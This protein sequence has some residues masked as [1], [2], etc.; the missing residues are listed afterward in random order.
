MTRLVPLSAAL[1]LV[2][3]LP[4][5]QALA[6]RLGGGR[7]IG[8]RPSVTQGMPR[9]GQPGA[10]LNRGQEQPQSG[11]QAGQP[12]AQGAQP[13]AQA[14]RPGGF[15]SRPGLGGLFGGLLMGGLLG[16]LFFGGGHGFGGPG[17]L[18]ILL[19]GGG[20]YLLFRVLRSR[21]QAAAPTGGPS[22]YDGPA[23]SGPIPGFEHL[24]RPAPAGRA[25]PDSPDADDRSDPAGPVAPPG[26]DANEFLEGAKTLYVRLQD[27]W[28]ARDLDDIA[29]FSSEALMRDIRDQA[30]ADTDRHK[31]EVLLVNAR[32]LEVRREGD[33]TR[34]SVYFDVL[35][36]E[37]PTAQ[38]PT[39]TREVWHFTRREDVSGDSW[40]LDGIQQLEA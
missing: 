7:S 17:L 18:D 10:P 11:L 21:R 3:T 14:A 8:N 20:L 28:S 25:G 6:A 27:A 13:G 19:I 24:S 30:A 9:P 23:P 35:L 39:Q 31:T 34:A 15:F 26:F 2:F 38:N 16:S 36:R 4:L 12:G 33:R 22:A 29:A 37:T 32:L 1:I 40:R 5:D